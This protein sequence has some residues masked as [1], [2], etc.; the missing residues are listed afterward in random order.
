[1]RRKSDQDR[2]AWQEER[3]AGA[4][5][6]Y[7]FALFFYTD[8][9]VSVLRH[10]LITVS[11]SVCSRVLG[12][13]RDASL[14]WLFGSS[15]A[16]DAVTTALRLP[17]LV[18]RLYGEGSLSLELAAHC[19]RFRY[20][21]PDG[22]L[23]LA[24][25]VGRLAVYWGA[26]MLVLCWVL[27]FPLIWLIAPGI[28]LRPEVQEQAVTLFRMCAGY[29][30]LAMLAAVATALLHG[31]ERFATPAL[32]GSAFNLTLIGCI[33][34]AAWGI[35]L[36]ASMVA[37]GVLL[38]GAAQL[39]VQVRELCVLWR[40]SQPL[41]VTDASAVNTQAR[42]IFARLPLGFSG[43]VAPQLM[44]VLTAAL[45]SLASDGSL[46]AL[47]YAERLMEFPIGVLGAAIGMASAPHLAKIVAEHGE[48]A[49]LPHMNTVMGVSLLLN[50]PA[51]AGLVAVAEPLT[52]MLLGHG[53]F[54]QEGVALT[55]AYL[56]AYAPGLPAY[57]LSRPLLAACHAVE[58]RRTP[59]RAL[60][61][62]LTFTL[63]SGVLLLFF[64]GRMGPP[65]GVALGLW[66][67]MLTLRHGLKKR[68]G[69]WSFP[70]PRLVR[71]VCGS[72]LVW[73]VADTATRWAG[74]S[75]KGLLW[76]VPAGIAA[77]ALVM[78]TER[79]TCEA[80]RHRIKLFWD[81][82]RR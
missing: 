25:R 19:V 53:A 60:L 71:T 27:A 42:K 7:I 81:R 29:M 15:A 67:Y 58:D 6:L 35:G 51:A 3:S 4:Y 65:L 17:Y 18:R 12:F 70:W 54:G 5:R 69:V 11:G 77:Y 24:A 61:F 50:L 80:L 72:V 31:R 39:L 74:G 62:G 44:F 10:S 49:L 30:P 13:V 82:S 59:V 32:T 22:D 14:A 38:G 33:G 26:A 34:A 40:R 76:A 52:R 1:M 66:V 16:A 73:M 21:Y 55:A 56:C 45:T 41:S 37:F 78:L 9:M 68:I 48:Q 79:G 57:G 8:T 28:G 2:R 75:A 47:F 46:S 36:P 43:A 64:M 23:F 63:V 20:L